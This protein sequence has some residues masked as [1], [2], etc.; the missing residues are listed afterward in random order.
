MAP[1]YKFLIGTVIAVI[2]LL[3]ALLALMLQK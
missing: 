3:L 2:G 1:D